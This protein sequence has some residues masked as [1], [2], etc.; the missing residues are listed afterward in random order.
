MANKAIDKHYLLESLKDFYTI[1]LLTFFQKKLT[2]TTV[3]D[4]PDNGDVIIYVGSTTSSFVQGHTYK[5]SLSSDEWIDITPTSSSGGTWGTITGTLS[6]QTDLQNALNGKATPIE[7]TQTEYD[8]LSSAQK[9]DA[10]K[11]YFIKNTVPGWEDFDFEGRYVWTDGINVYY[12][13]EEDQ[14]KLN[15]S[16][17]EEMTWTG[18]TEFYGDCVWT[19][20]TYIYY[21][22]DSST[23]YKLNGTTW[24]SMT[25]SGLTDFAGNSIWTYGNDIYWSYGSDQ[26]KLN[27]TT[28]EPVTWETPSAWGYLGYNIW[29]D[30]T[31]T[32][33]SDL[34]GSVQQKFNGT[35][36]EEMTWTGFQPGWG[37]FIW[38]DGTDIYY[39]YGSD[40]Y[41]LNGTTWESVTWSGLTDF[42]GTSICTDGSNIYH[43]YGRD[44]YKLNNTTWT[45]I[46]TTTYGA[47]IYY[48][49]IPYPKEYVPE[50]GDIIGT[51]SNQTDL[52]EVL[53][54]KATPIEVTQSEYDALTPTQKTDESKVYFTVERNQLWNGYT[55][56]E[57]TDI[58]TDGNNIYYSL[59]GDTY[60]LN[61]NTWETAGYCTDVNGKDIW[62]DGTNIYYSGG[63]YQYKLNGTTWET[64]TW[65]ELSSKSAYFHGEFVWTDGNNI[66]WSYSSDQYKFNGTTWES[67]TWDSTGFE[68]PLGDNIWTDGTNIYW[69][70][71]YNQYK[72]NGT[73]WEPMTWFGLTNFEGQFIWSDGINIYYSYKYESVLNQ[74][75]KL[76]GTTWEEI[77][78]NGLTNPDGRYIWTDGINMYYSN[79]TN[80]QYILNGNTWEPFIADGEKIYYKNVPYGEKHKILKNTFAANATSVSINI[81]SLD[82]NKHNYG[83]KYYSTVGV[84]C[85]STSY[86]SSTGVYTVNFKQAAPSAGTFYIEA[87]KMS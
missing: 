68:T 55:D 37:M 36:W 53:D 71:A 75:Y 67:M 74:Q 31:N 7:L 78:W 60:K 56:I 83:F 87:H 26:Y 51:L 34:S 4:D 62:S 18:L 86:N 24:V 33:Y 69:S 57:G 22:E 40:Q 23:Q 2:V 82:L 17:W 10:S 81:S 14:Y 11:V 80:S 21:S 84:K 16:T 9:T 12:S 77:E 73:K 41:K 6:D 3:P 48:K 66:Y 63:I 79:G 25:W 49:D 65:P 64:I 8:A 5:Y 50:W 58:W 20:G 27:G 42:D 72:L 47:K 85:G 54:E 28:W 76:N 52:Q 15:G 32:Y 44:N 35:S 29:T 43:L 38:T 45:E 59:G 46:T 30:G 1:I 19:D 13:Y 70:Y 61:G 39:S